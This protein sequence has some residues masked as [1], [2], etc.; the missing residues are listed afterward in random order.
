[1]VIVTEFTTWDGVHG[2]LMGV[3]AAARRLRTRPANLEPV[4][5]RKVAQGT[6][7]R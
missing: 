6:R 7:V 5:T 4:S 2:D 1:M 3:I